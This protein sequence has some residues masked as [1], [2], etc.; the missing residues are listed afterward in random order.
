MKTVRKNKCLFILSVVLGALLVVF[1]CTAFAKDLPKI[2][3][4]LQCAYPPGDYAADVGIPAQIEYVKERTGGKFIITRYFGGEIMPTDEILTGVGVGLAEMGEGAASYWSGIEPVLALN[5]GLPG[6]GMDPVGDA[7]AFQNNSKWSLMLSE[8][9]AKHGCEYLGWHA[10]GPYPIFCSNKP[11]RKVEDWKG[12]KIRVTGASADLLQA[13]GASTVYIPGA[14][15]GQ[16][17]VTHTIDVGS[18]TAECIMDLGFGSMMDYLILPAFTENCGGTTIVNKKA[19]EKLPYEYQKILKESELLFHLTMADHLKKM[20]NDNINLAEG[21]GKGP[22]AYEVIYFSD[23][24]I[25]KMN[26]LVRGVVWDG[27]AKKSPE[28]A[29]AVDLLKEW[30]PDR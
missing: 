20:M 10:Y 29:K 2:H 1:A 7:Y 23:E 18:W 25:A 24:E 27:W 17:L 8:I 30:Y 12:I 11:I 5:Y 28:C 9:Y 15:I 3:W 19:W 13:M 22:R 4:R 6:M 16:A 21:V 26:H 14:E